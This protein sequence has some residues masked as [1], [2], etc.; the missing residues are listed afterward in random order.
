MCFV[1]GGPMSCP[2]AAVV[3]HPTKK[4]LPKSRFLVGAQ[5]GNR[6]RTTF[7]QGILSPSRLPIPPSA[8]L[9]ARTGV[10]P[11]YKVLQ[12]SA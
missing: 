12:T 4:R 9:E 10:E 2:A 1:W 6:T 7:G 11:V 8:H 5:S 3:I